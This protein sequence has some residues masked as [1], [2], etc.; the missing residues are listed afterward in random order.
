LPI[1]RWT[2]AAAFVI[3]CLCL[4]LPGPPPR[5]QTMDD[6]IVSKHVRVRI[7][8]ERQWLGRDSIV[9]LER[10]WDFVQRATKGSLPGRVLVEIEWK[11]A[12][13]TFDAGRSVVSIGMNHSAAARD[14]KGFLLHNAAREL[15]RIALL[16]LSQGGVSKEENRFLHEGMAEILAREF[17]GTTKRLG[18]AWAICYYL[19][20]M[21][22]LGTKE[23]AGRP[24]LFRG[25]DLRA[26]A[27]GITFLTF[28]REL[29]GRDRILKLFELLA[30][31]SLEDS[32]ALAFRPPATLLEAEWLKRVRSYTPGDVT[33]AGEESAPV[34][35]KVS[36]V[37][38]QGK[39]GAPL[40]MRVFAR[41]EDRDLLP[42][43]IF[44]VD[45]T[46][47][48]VLQGLP[49]KPAEGSHV[50]FTIP[51]EAEREA[52]RYRVR[53]VAI[54]EGGNLREWDAHYTVVR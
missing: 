45:E 42:N 30:T 32:L 14:L 54:D 35:D 26:A 6:S 11:D 25:R 17:S 49:A 43:G 36:F 23:L 47:G 41:D 20:R 13:S 37:P 21:N 1:L 7:P 38:E 16:T 15:A 24:E 48:K 22:P 52:G 27:P 9:E 40:T 3:A 18:A 2:C 51:V 5:A 44:V 8:V 28:C 34:L 39:A 29:Y 50:V 10:C 19:D 12:N 31:K 46:S 53:L 33:V 4:L